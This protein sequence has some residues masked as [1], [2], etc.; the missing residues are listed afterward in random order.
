MKPTSKKSFKKADRDTSWGKV[1]RW[2]GDHLQKDDTYHTKVI[3]PNL[4]RMA[5]VKKGAPVLDLGCGEGFFTRALSKEGAQATGVDI[6]KELVMRARAQGG[7]EYMVAPSNK[8]SFAKDKAFDLVVCV[9]ALQNIEDLQGTLKEVRRVLAPHG[10]FICVLNH[11]AFRVLK[12]S[13]WGWDEVLDTQYRR[14]DGYLS[15]AKVFVDMHPG[16]SK[17]V[18]TISYH[19]SLQDI[20]KAFKAAGLAVAGL[21]EWVS[22]RASGKGPRQGAE[23]IARKEIPLF[24]ALEAM[25]ST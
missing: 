15:A 10:R 23:D 20:F 11:P 8:L 16:A 6:A 21:E 7:A 18:R 13:S 9:L 17:T 14:V 1:A 4:L 12:R 5:G 2:Y 22:H 25:L 3:L 24:M 19:R